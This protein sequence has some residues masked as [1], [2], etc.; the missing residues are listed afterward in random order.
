M[1]SRID[2]GFGESIL[3][4]RRSGTFV[5]VIAFESVRNQIYERIMRKEIR[6]STRQFDLRILGS[7]ENLEMCV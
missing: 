7:A 2:F 3:T 6:I 4:C 1:V 5:V